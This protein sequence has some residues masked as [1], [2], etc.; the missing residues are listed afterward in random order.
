MANEK[1][2]DGS[3]HSVSAVRGLDALSFIEGLQREA[4]CALREVIRLLRVDDSARFSDILKAAATVQTLSHSLV[5]ELF[6][7]PVLG[8]TNMLHFLTEMLG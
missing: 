5:T 3:P 4:R 7:Q 2:K 6:F 1:Y 8:N